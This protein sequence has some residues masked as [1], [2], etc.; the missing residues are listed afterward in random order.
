MTSLIYNDCY[1]NQIIQFIADDR[2]TR[3][4]LRIWHLNIRCLNSNY[5]ELKASLSEVKND[6]DVIALSET[7]NYNL[8]NLGQVLPGYNFFYLKSEINRCGGVAVFIKKSIKIT[9]IEYNKLIEC[10]DMWIYCETD[11]SKRNCIACI[12]RSPSTNMSKF[13][14]SLN[15]RLKGLSHK[16]KENMIMAGD[17]NI[18]LKNEKDKHSMCFYDKLLEANFSPLITTPTRSTNQSQTIID[19]IFIHNSLLMNKQDV[20]Y[21]GNLF[22]GITDHNAQYLIIK[23]E[24]KQNSIKNRGFKRN[25]TQVNMQRFTEF[26]KN[27][28]F[29]KETEKCTVNDVFSEFK[30]KIKQAHDKSF[31]LQRISRKQFANKDWFNQ[32]LKKYHRKKVKLYKKWKKTKSQTDED[33]YKAFSKDY[34][35]KLKSVER[36]FYMDKFNMIKKDTKALWKSLNQIRG[37]DSSK[38]QNI[39]IKEI[40]TENTVISDSKLIANYMNEYYINIAKNL[41]C[42]NSAEKCTTTKMEYLS[43]SYRYDEISIQE[44]I[45]TMRSMNNRKSSNDYVPIKVF[46]ECSNLVFEHLCKLFNFSISSGVFPDALKYSKIVPIYKRGKKDDPGNYRPVSILSYIDKIF[47]KLVH[48]RIYTFLENNDYFNMSQFGFRKNHSTSMALLKMTDKLIKSKANNQFIV[49]LNIDISKAFDTVDHEILL[50]ILYYCGIRG[51]MH[52][53]FR[54]YLTNRKQ[55]TFVNG[56]YSDILA[57]KAGVPQGSSLGPLLF[58]MYIN[59]IKKYLCEE[60]VN[61]YADDTNIFISDGDAKTLK[62]KAEKVL[63][64]IDNYMKIKKLALNTNKTEYIFLTPRNKMTEE[65]TIME[66]KLSGDI[67]TR[68][69]YTKFLGLIIDDKLQFNFHIQHVINKLKKFIPL[70]YRLRDLV[71]LD[72]ITLLN[73]QLCSSI[74]RYCL[75]VYG[76]ANKSIIKR[77]SR[78]R[79]TL[80]KII[81]RKEKMHLDIDFYKNKGL[82]DLESMYDY[83]LLILAYKLKYLQHTLPK[84]FHNYMLN[85]ENTQLRT[86]N[87]F[88]LPLLN[89]VL[90]QRQSWYKMSFKWNELP[91][92]LK[93]INTIKKFKKEIRDYLSN[94]MDSF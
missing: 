72:I 28:L 25:Y 37:T 51:F 8:E 66:L 92:R 50:R 35:K 1:P 14:E 54:T 11:T 57:N 67:I 77:L 78:I 34:K 49:G 48:K 15:N 5:R 31:P 39:E 9:D 33:N 4:M 36:K 69:E 47:E 40:K 7:W 62:S 64:K 26:T 53:W 18:N 6:I 30:E 56:Q 76:S 2:L 32:E 86:K 3:D 93:N 82:L 80:I 60:E 46:K 58:I 81:Y 21:V 94:K 24:T 29:T 68:V 88:V 17:F 90:E 43:N 85:N 89:T 83:E 74:V 87:N 19:Q 45:K 70:F 71:P 23:K 27:I 44:V 41:T 59:D 91:N 73:E 13:T 20:K 10:D 16:T 79:K 55:T 65:R 75:I 12:Y 84:A 52:E 38:T 61:I 63:E 42:Y 22:L